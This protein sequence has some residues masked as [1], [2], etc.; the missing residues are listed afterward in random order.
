M[1]IFALFA[2][3]FFLFLN[4]EICSKRDRLINPSTLFFSLWSFILLLSNVDLL[5]I[6]KPSDDAYFLILLMLL[7]FFAGSLRMH[8]SSKTTAIKK[9]YA[10]NFKMY[11]FLVGIL[12]SFTMIDCIIAIK[13]L[14]DGI[15][16]W[17]I[18]GWRMAPFGLSDNP[19]LARRS[20]VEEIFRAS[21][22]TPFEAIIPPVTAY[23]F[24]YPGKN[25]T[26]RKI[27][28]LSSLCVLVLSSVAGGGGRLGYIYYFG[29]FLLAFFTLPSYR[30]KHYKKY[31]LIVLIFAL[32][33]IFLFTSIRAGSEGYAAFI[34]LFCQFYKYFAIP[35][36][37]LSLW[38]PNLY[39]TEHSYGMLVS[40]GIHSYFFRALKIL[41][42]NSFVPEVYDITFT[43]ILNAEKFLDVGYGVANAFVTPIYYFYIDGGVSGVC[44]FSFIL[45]KI[46]AVYY[47]KF[48][49]DINIKSFVIYAL[50]FYGVFLTFIRLQVCMPSYM[51]SFFIAMVIFKPNRNE[52]ELFS[53]RYYLS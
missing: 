53:K 46:A 35:P 24:F 42:L 8:I 1:G 29:C 38:L 30:K 5:G 49:S 22:L 44:F 26:R 33:I 51:I 15:P 47:K 16:A 36:T 23:Y 20:L 27:L 2:A 13:G 6:Y 25:R 10:L 14:L 48:R 41:N 4:L 17:Q 39:E 50:I 43:N 21:I 52:I 28:L 19:M 32:I 45:S 31:L 37:L 12:L 9:T 18:R 11:F 34:T 7:F 3:A 40:F